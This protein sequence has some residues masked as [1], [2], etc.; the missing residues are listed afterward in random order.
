MIPIL[1]SLL[2][3]PAENLDL[4]AVF[5]L[6]VLVVPL[7]PTGTLLARADL[8]PWAT[9]VIAVAG[10]LRGRTLGD[11]PLPSLTARRWP[12]GVRLRQASRVTGPLASMLWFDAAAG[13]T[14]PALYAAIAT[15]AVTV[16]L[17]RFAGR[18]GLTAWFP[19][20]HQPIRGWIVRSLLTIA[21][22]VAAGLSS[23]PLAG[24]A[25]IWLPISAYVGVLFHSLGLLED[26][27]QSRAQRVAA[28]RRDGHPHRPTRHRYLLAAA[29]PSLGLLLLLWLHVGLIGP[30]GFEQAPVVTLHILAWTGILLPRRTPM[31][32]SCLLHEVVPVGGRDPGAQPGRVVPFDEPPAGALRMDPVAVKRLRVLHHW[33]VPVRDPRLEVLDDPIR[34]LWPRQNPPIAHHALGDGSFEPDPITGRSQLFEITVRLRE[35]ADMG[36]VDEHNAQQRRMVVLRPF[37]DWWAT[38]RRQGRTYRW[39]R[40]LPANAMTVVDAST[41]SL[42]LRD[43][44]LLVLSTEG[45]ARAYEL[46]IGAPVFD[47]D[48]FGRQRPPQLED[49][50]AGGG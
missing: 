30:V 48:A 4:L 1:R 7:V 36:R 27:L 11:G 49:Y 33:V 3:T 41:R 6:S 26:R 16:V 9:A 34:P 17:R 38:L 31:A 47:L 42:S 25:L 13:L 37:A 29:G 21:A 39:D 15:T 12:L 23:R 24:S 18:D 8:V 14:L 40:A 50:V 28:G 35:Q 32:V 43:G 22:V 44:D 19:R 10:L 45:V 5:G 20:G 46:E 2:G